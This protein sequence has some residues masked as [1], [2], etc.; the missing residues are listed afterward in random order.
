[1]SLVGHLSNKWKHSNSLLCVMATLL[2]LVATCDW[3]DLNQLLHRWSVGSVLEKPEGTPAGP[4]R[5]NM[6]G[7]WATTAIHAPL[8]KPEQ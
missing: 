6:G 7:S 8:P 4:R 1:M 5:V 3:D 2:P